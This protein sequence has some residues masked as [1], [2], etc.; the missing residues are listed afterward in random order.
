VPARVHAVKVPVT[1]VC[2]RVTVPVG[3]TAVP[4]AVSVTETEHVEPWFITTGVVQLIVVEVDL[5]G[6][7]VTEIIEVPL[8]A[9]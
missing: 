5:S 9:K 1:P 3:V 4:V 2:D 6:T 7:E 8:L